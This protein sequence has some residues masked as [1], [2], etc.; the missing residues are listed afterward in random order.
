M[1]NKILFVLGTPA[2]GSTLLSLMLDSHPQ[3]FTVGELSN[4]PRLYQNKKRI[5]SICEDRCNFWDRQFSQ[6]E[7]Q[8]LSRGLANVR[9]SPAIPLKVDKFFR[10][11]VNDEIFRPYSVIAAKTP[12]NILVDSTK[13]IYWI[14]EMLQRKE[15]QKE[16]DIYLLHLVRDGRAVLNSYIRKRRNK[17]I[18]YLSNFW[19]NRVT[20]N[21]IFFEK[22]S[23]GHKMLL[24]Y[25]ELATMPQE[26]L[27]EI[28]NFLGIEY[29]MEMIPYWKYEHH[30]ISGNSK[31]NSLANKYRNRKEDSQNLNDFSVKINLNWRQKLREDTIQEFY[32][33]IGDRNKP[34]EWND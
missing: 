20:N 8:K 13:T 19:L 2:C 29:S 24:R 5:C 31:T 25:E 30:I 34:Y 21:E 4:L 11:I 32:A 33:I 12:A 6:K 17:N 3:C 15:I 9:I 23:L 27:Q 16:F 28:C 10:E 22:F 1:K 18:E 7:L 14:S 26:K